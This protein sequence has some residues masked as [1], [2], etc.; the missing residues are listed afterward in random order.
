MQFFVSSLFLIN[1]TLMV[2]ILRNFMFMQ[3]EHMRSWHAEAL[4][5]LQRIVFPTLSDEERLKAAHY[6]RH[7][8]IFPQGQFVLTT[9]A[10]GQV[11]PLSGEGQ[12]PLLIGMTTTMRTGFDFAHY[13]HTFSETMAGGWMSN[14]QPHGTWLYGLDM[15]IHPAHRGRGGARLLYR[16]R[17]QLVRQLQLQGQLTVGMMSGY[18]AISAQLSGE[19]YYQAWIKGDLWD[20]TLSPQRKIGFEPLGLIPGY[21]H[22]PGCGN[23]GVLLRLDAGKDV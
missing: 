9:T 17:H 10:E 11:P 19:A 8:D 16:A 21:L 2:R 7:L 13:Q 5:E 15:G 14:H 23:Y 12:L 3:T 6:R 18:G 4:E 22:D 1:V 20:P